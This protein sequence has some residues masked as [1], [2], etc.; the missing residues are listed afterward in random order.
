MKTLLYRKFNSG[1]AAGATTSNKDLIKTQ[2]V[3]N[4]F[5]DQ[6]NQVRPN[7]AYLMFKFLEKAAKGNNGRV[8]ANII[9]DVALGNDVAGI[10]SDDFQV[11]FLDISNVHQWRLIFIQITR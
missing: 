9:L 10:K 4:Q 7:D 11:N 5:G 6:I 2:L 8:P 1:A 3:A